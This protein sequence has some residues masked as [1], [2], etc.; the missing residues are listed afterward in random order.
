MLRPSMMVQTQPWVRLATAPLVFL[1]RCRPEWRYAYLRHTSRIS[2]GIKQMPE[3]RTSAELAE[4]RRAGDDRRDEDFGGRA[5]ERRHRPERR[6][7]IINEDGVSFAEWV[8][9]M[10]RY[11]A[12]I[13]WARAKAIRE[14]RSKGRSDPP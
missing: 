7:P 4:D 14:Y 11:Q 8:R 5:V 13:V 6:M 10:V 2:R 9:A 3:Q 12:R 1:P